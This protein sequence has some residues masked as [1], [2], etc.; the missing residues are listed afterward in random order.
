RPTW[1]G[2]LRPTT[3]WPSACCAGS[4]SGASGCPTTWPSSAW[5]T[6]TSAASPPPPCRRSPSWPPSGGGLRGS[7][8]WT[9]SRG[10]RRGSGSG[11]GADGGGAPPGPERGAGAGGVAA[12]DRPPAAHRA[13][14]HQPAPRGAGRPAAP[15]PE[16]REAGLMHGKA[17][18]GPSL[19]LLIPAVLPILLLSVIPLLQGM[20][21][22]FTDYRLGPR[23][24][25]FTGLDNYQY[26]LTDY[27][28]W[29]SFKAGAIWAVAVTAGEIILGLG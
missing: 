14:V 12:G 17:R 10:G 7:S 16:C 28:F 4:G 22:G 19:W 1:M 8:S 15:G 5:T 6:S 20:S 2:S 21:L 23:E 9:G 27:K 25:Q 26:M 3:P 13:G 11:G 18:T 24:P 29:S